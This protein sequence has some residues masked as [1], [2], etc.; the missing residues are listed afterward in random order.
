MSTRPGSTGRLAAV[1]GALV[2]ALAACGG[3][4]APSTSPAGSATP[5]PA[6][7]LPIDMPSI[8]IPS[9]QSDVDLEGQIP[10][11]FCNQ[12]T[13]KM[14]FSGPDA[15][16]NDET[17]A[18]IVTALGRSPSD[19]SVAFATVEGPECQ[20]VS[21]IAFRIKGADQGRFEQL[22]IAA[23]EEDS[24][25]RPTRSNLAGKDVWVFTDS[26]GTTSYI[27]FRGD[28]IYGVS[29]ETE[30]DAGKGLAVLP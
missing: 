16:G 10:D 26:S 8:D 29:A 28:T 21:L 9:F 18:A 13:Q 12:A 19:V 24:G 17:F 25:T 1:L 14:S 5:A 7:S 4:A 3:A 30:A 11:T 6:A 2:L 20:G 15:V 22:F 27:Y 23:Q